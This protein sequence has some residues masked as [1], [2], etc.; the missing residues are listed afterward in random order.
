MSL[1]RFLGHKLDLPRMGQWQMETNGETDVCWTCCNWNYTLIFWNT[2]IGDF[3]FINSVNIDP[4]AKR[5]VVAKIRD[6]NP[7]TYREK[8]DLPLYFSDITDW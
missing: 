2:T 3:N 7:E 5:E 6:T 1:S 4:K 8:E